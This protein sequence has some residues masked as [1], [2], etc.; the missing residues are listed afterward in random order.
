MRHWIY[1]NRIQ[2]ERI[3]PLSSAPML[4]LSQ[5]KRVKRTPSMQ[6]SLHINKVSYELITL[7]WMW[8]V[9]LSIKIHLTIEME[10]KSKKLLVQERYIDSLNLVFQGKITLCHFKYSHSKKGRWNGSQWSKLSRLLDWDHQIVQ[11][12]GNATYESGKIE[13]K[14]WYF[15]NF[16]SLPQCLRF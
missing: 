10:A 14:L 5:K 6:A 12:G 13:A 2:M 9:M 4:L 8:I 15:Q 1:T 7:T 16:G 3:H 11:L